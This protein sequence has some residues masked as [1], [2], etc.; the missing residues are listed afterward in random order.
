VPLYEYRCTDCDTVF[1]QRRP[2]AESDADV[3]CP[4]GHAGARRLLSV[5]AST[6]S[7]GAPAPAAVPSGGMGCGPACACH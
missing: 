4:D 2:M 5:F 7:G 3:R 6:R 1:E